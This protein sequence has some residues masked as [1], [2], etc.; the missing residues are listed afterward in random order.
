MPPSGS[1]RL[2]ALRVTVRELATAVAAATG[3][4][5][6][7][8]SFER[9]DALE[10]QFGRLPVLSTQVAD[11]LGFSND[12]ELAALVARALRDAGHPDAAGARS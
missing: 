9:D 10:R 1:C 8:V 11:S 7:L 2:P 4:D 3:C 5:M 6:S 12:G